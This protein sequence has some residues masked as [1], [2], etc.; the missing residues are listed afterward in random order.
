MHG[1]LEDFGPEFM[2]AALMAS[3]HFES[4]GEHAGVAFDC[5]FV[6]KLNH[7]RGHTLGTRLFSGCNV[8]R[9]LAETNQRH[10]AGHAATPM[11]R[12]EAGCVHFF[13]FLSFGSKAFR[14]KAVA[15]TPAWPCG[16]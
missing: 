16:P 9:L 2:F 10:V 15:A 14:R 1:L 5:P 6:E 4:L 11:P 8:R 12:S 7:L 3:V 13:G